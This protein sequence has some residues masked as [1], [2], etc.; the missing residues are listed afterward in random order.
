MI[1]FTC[2]YRAYRV[3]DPFAAQ[4]AVSGW[5]V[6]LHCF[7]AGLALLLAPLQLS[8]GVRSRAPQKRPR[9]C[10]AFRQSPGQMDYDTIGSLNASI[11][12]SYS[13]IGTQAQNTFLSP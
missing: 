7:A 11:S 10:G 13:L 9:A 5:D 3:G 8:A 12:P 2:L 6:P 1:G 4:F